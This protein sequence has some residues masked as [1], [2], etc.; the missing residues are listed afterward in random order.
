MI[1]YKSQ[2]RSWVCFS[3]EADIS[4]SVSGTEAQGRDPRMTGRVVECPIDEMNR[5]RG[6]RGAALRIP[7]AE[8]EVGIL[9]TGWGGE[10]ATCR[11]FA[12]T[13]GTTPRRS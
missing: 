7:P 6:A 12:P 11:K 5:L 13:P 10:Q 3:L 1:I 8:P 4:Q 9:F 2:A